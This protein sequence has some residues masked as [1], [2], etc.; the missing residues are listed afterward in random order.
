MLDTGSEHRPGRTLKNSATLLVFVLLAFAAF[1][2][3]QSWRNT[4]SEQ[5]VQMATIAALSGNSIDIYFTQLRIG[6]QGLGTE[7]AA[8]G[9]KPDLDR[10]YALVRRFQYLHTELD[11]VM[12][13]RGDGQVLLTGTTPYGPDLPTLANDPAF[14]QLREELQQGSPF[15]IGRP[16]TGYI[17]RSWIVSARYAVT[18]PAGK[19]AYIIS[20]N[21]PVDMMQRYWMDTVTPRITA[22]GLVRDDGYLVSRYPE[23]DAANRDELYGKPLE[24]AMAEYLRTNSHPDQGLVELR[25]S[26]GKKTDL[27]V[28]RR[29][30]HYPLTLFVEM[31]VTEI[32]SAWREELHAPYFVMALILACTFAFYSLR[33]QRRA[34]TAEKRRKELQRH[35]EHALR[36]RS[37]NEIIMFD[38]GT[39][40]IT[41]ANDQALE[42][43]G[44]SLEQLQKKNMLALQPET[45]IESFGEKLELLRRGEQEAVTYQTVQVRADGSSYPVEVNL[46]LITLE[47]GV[48]KFLA[49]VHD[50]SALREAEENIRRFNTPIER[51]GGGTSK[52]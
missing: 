48:E 11:N 19:L 4:K 46:Q 12:L 26:A 15:V 29:L 2:V 42:S 1:L 20:A 30:Q 18:D 13:I 28:M 33:Q 17:D 16:V 37:P 9:G 43:L 39:L 47:D 3:A 5:A 25:N 21:L 23:P 14:L 50:I 27:L 6:M 7:L 45:G 44:Y 31:P 51:R 8:M 24:G 49:V 52:E 40:L 34:W 38:T 41:Y 36:E 32:K 35:Y 22:L 10:A